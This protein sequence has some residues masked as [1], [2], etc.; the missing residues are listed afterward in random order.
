[1]SKIRVADYIVSRFYDFGVRDAFIVTG[2]GAMHLNDA[3]SRNKK[4]KN[5]YFHHEQAAAM[6]ADGY[7]RL[8]NKCA[9]VNVTTG[10]GGVNALNGIFGAYT[11]SLNVIVISGQVK[12][13]TYYKAYSEKILQE[14]EAYKKQVVAAAEGEAS[15]FLAI[16]NEYKSAKQ[17][18]QERMYLE[19]ME[20][21]LADIDK[22]I[23]DKNSGSGVVPYLALPELKKKDPS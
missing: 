16:Y 18:T 19:T 8:S 3:I 2:G 13:E 15:R 20:K 1:M 21:V 4:I 10:P 5:T 6:A 11:D 7:N 14:A 9:I 22:T 17:V 12:N 23:I